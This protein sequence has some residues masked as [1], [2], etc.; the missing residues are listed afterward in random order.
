MIASGDQLLKDKEALSSEI[1]TLTGERERLVGDNQKL[2]MEL[3]TL[4][5]D[6]K[7]LL[8]DKEA[9]DASNLS[10]SNE[11]GNLK[12]KCDELAALNLIR[13]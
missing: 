2:N 9:A 12:T 10:L 11:I 13:L 4:M 3:K 7:K 5:E 1:K 6:S 8:S